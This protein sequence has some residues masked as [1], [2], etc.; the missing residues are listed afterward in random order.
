M[1]LAEKISFLKF[2]IFTTMLTRDESLRIPNGE[3]SSGIDEVFPR[4]RR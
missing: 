1:S 4:V 2:K 3:N